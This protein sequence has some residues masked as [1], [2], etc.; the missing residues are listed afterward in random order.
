MNTY[1]AGEGGDL[2]ER[3]AENREWVFPLLADSGARHRIVMLEGFDLTRRPSCEPTL[4][5]LVSDDWSPE[6][7]YHVGWCESCR[8]AGFS[9]RVGAFSGGRPAPAPNRRRAALVAVATAAL[10]IIPV[11]GSQ[12]VENPFGGGGGTSAQPGGTGNGGT[13][14]G[15]QS[16]GPGSTTGTQPGPVT[17]GSTGTTGTTGTTPTTTPSTGTVTPKPRSRPLGTNGEH[18]GTR[19]HSALP[20]TT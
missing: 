20:L 6:A 2:A 13:T 9:L 19:G 4:Y 14:T 8:N 17:T 18:A 12:I 5:A 16:S 3:A 11:A 10:I 7:I 1:K 15:N